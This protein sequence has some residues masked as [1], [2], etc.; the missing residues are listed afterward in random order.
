MADVARLLPRLWDGRR[1]LQFL[2]G[3]ALIALA[4]AAPA[5]AAAP[6]PQAPAVVVTTVDA[7]L[8]GSAADRIAEPTPAAAGAPAESPATVV[9]SVD[10]TA[11]GPLCDRDD[12]H[13]GSVAQRPHAGRGPPLA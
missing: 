9:L 4:F 7:P 6:E 8:S 2:A 3:L 10:R 1:L 5:L 11:T 13:P 12:R